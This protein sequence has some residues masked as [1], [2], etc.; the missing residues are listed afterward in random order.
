MKVFVETDRLLLRE[1]LPNDAE[2]LFEMDSD[3]LV[4]QYLGNNPL[5]DISASRSII[6]MVRKQ[7]NDYGIGRWA[8]VLKE[9][10][11]MIGWAGLK[12]E[13]SLAEKGNYYDL[14]YRLKQKHWNKGFA[15]EAAKASLSFGFENLKLTKINAAAH[16]DNL[17]SNKIIQNIGFKFID[18][19]HWQDELCN[20]Y[21]IYR[22]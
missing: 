11:E 3:P 18:Q 10:N 13:T 4:H 2:D 14:G 15:S 17:A 8:I 22:L 1:I 5:K 6:E 7:Y 19:F 9:T 12:F 21:E 16:V 20:W